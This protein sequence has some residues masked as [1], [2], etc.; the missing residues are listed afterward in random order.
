MDFEVC[1]WLCALTLAPLVTSSLTTSVCPA[2][3][4]MC[5]AVFPFWIR[6]DRETTARANEWHILINPSTTCLC[7]PIQ[8]GV[9][10][11]WHPTAIPYPLPERCC[12]RWPVIYL[13]THTSFLQSECSTRGFLYPVWTCSQEQRTPCDIKHRHKHLLKLCVCVCQTDLGCCIYV[14]AQFEQLGHHLHMPLFGCQMQCIQPILKHTAQVLLVNRMV[15]V[16][17][18]IP[19]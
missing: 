10:S 9:L 17:S 5:S 12:F 2:S 1:T 15:M 11:H 7:H 13:Q 6:I 16:T 18:S 8:R 3:E 4:A 19:I 14:G